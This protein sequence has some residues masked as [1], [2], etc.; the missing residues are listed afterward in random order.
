MNEL[1]ETAASSGSLCWVSHSQRQHCR[2]EVVPGVRN[3]GSSGSSRGRPHRGL[4]LLGGSTWG[5]V[6]GGGAAEVTC[7]QQWGKCAPLLDQAPVQARATLCPSLFV[8]ALL[9]EHCSPA[10]GCG[11]EVTAPVA[12]CMWLLLAGS[13]FS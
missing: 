3:Q 1:L 5:S 4:G 6:L 7:F 11:S 13:V 2:A 10:A 12:V 8:L 9:K